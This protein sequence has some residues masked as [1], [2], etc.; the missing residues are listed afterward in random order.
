[1][2]SLDTMWGFIGDAGV[3]L[4]KFGEDVK[5]LVDRII[6]LMRLGWRAQAR[7]EELPSDLPL[8]QLTSEA[9]NLS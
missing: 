3:M 4:G 7:A 2:N 1:M 5:P 6:E 9:D 8:P